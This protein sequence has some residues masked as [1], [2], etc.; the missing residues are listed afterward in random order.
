MVLKNERQA[1]GRD[2]THVFNVCFSQMENLANFESF[3][4]CHLTFFFLNNNLYD[5]Y[6]N[7]LLKVVKHRYLTRQSANFDDDIFSFPV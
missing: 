4:L 3:Y 6:C 2:S 5:C 7:I 1:G